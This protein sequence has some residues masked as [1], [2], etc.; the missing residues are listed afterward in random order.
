M[1]ALKI[2][3]FLSCGVMFSACPGANYENAADKLFKN[4]MDLP[5]PQKGYHDG[6][7]YKISSLFEDSYSA[8][9]VLKNN[10]TTKVI[11]DL[12]LNF[13]IESFTRAEAEA[14]KFNFSEE[15]D[16]LNAVHDNY[17]YARQRSLDSYFTSIKKPVNKKVGFKGVFQTIKG[18]GLEEYE[19]EDLLYLTATIEVGEKFYVFQLIGKSENMGYLKDDFE[20][21]L[22]SIEK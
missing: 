16:L 20:D 14:F 4:G 15:T 5:D 19:S 3:V 10:A 7:K 21:I 13:S 9:F 22:N 12:D 1:K 11:Y 17:V 8:D 18:S 2:F 6:I